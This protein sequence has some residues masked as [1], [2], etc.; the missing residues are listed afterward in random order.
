MINTFTP[1]PINASDQI[2]INKP[3]FQK[4]VKAL[5]QNGVYVPAINK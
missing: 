5:I 3:H 1:M 4:P 2:M